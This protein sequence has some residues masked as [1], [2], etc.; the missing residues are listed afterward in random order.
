MSGCTVFVFCSLMEYALVNIVLGD[1]IEGDDSA[2][3]RGMKSI[4]VA[5]GFGSH[6]LVSRA[7]H[8]F[9]LR[10]F[11][12]VEAKKNKKKT[13][14][15]KP[16]RSASILPRNVDVRDRPREVGGQKTCRALNDARLRR[17]SG[18]IDVDVEKRNQKKKNDHRF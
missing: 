18:Q 9:V 5:T 16:N 14:K 6:Q 4:F 11:V 13:N 17:P 10:R 12:V 2:L 7:I 1:F 8:S 15:K 3:K